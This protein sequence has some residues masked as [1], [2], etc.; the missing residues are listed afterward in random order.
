MCEEIKK[1]TQKTTNTRDGVVFTN[2][3]FQSCH[4]PASTAADAAVINMA[5]PGMDGGFRSM[6][7][8]TP[9]E[10]TIP[11]ARQDFMNSLKLGPDAGR[12]TNLVADIDGARP[13]PGAGQYTNKQTYYEPTDIRGAGPMKLIRNTN[14][15]DYS[16]KLDDIDGAQPKPYTFKTKREVNP[17]MPQYKLPSAEMAEPTVPKF[18]RDS[19][20]IGDIEGTKPRPRHRFA[21]VRLW[22]VGGGFSPPNTHAFSPSLPA[23]FG[24][25]AFLTHRRHCPTRL[26]LSALRSVRITPCWT[27]R[28]H[29]RTGS[30]GTCAL[31]SKLHRRRPCSM[32]RIL[33]TW[34]LSPAGPLTHRP[35]CT[36]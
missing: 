18:I 6:S 22:K 15:I 4:C 2:A 10:C 30:H 28:V 14:A 11:N 35:L 8:A 36:G 20:N 5:L 21:T 32:Y 13:A 19:Y 25:A 31:A 23:C 7:L 26:C 34:A 16:M 33:T 12:P 9:G 1:T 3:A 29:R 27:L 24:F 17:L